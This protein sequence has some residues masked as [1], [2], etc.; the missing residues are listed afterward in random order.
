MRSNSNHGVLR[1]KNNFHT[2][3][4]DPVIAII[5]HSLTKYTQDSSTCTDVTFMGK[6]YTC[7]VSIASGGSAADL[8]TWEG[9]IL[10]SFGFGFRVPVAGFGDQ[11]NLKC[12][13]KACVCATFLWMHWRIP[14]IMCFYV[15][16]QR[17]YKKRVRVCT[18]FFCRCADAFHK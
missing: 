17:I 3:S 9:R 14:Q 2:R 1:F 12:V 4:S 16:R 13:L 8:E 15:V 5:L 7:P 11:V 6:C 10:N 18:T